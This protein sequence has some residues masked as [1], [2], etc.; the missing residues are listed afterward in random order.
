MI[1]VA[2]KE[3]GKLAKLARRVEDWILGTDA[4]QGRPITPEDIT[5]QG[6]DTRG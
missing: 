1:T 3:K 5:G 2:D 4:E 6:G